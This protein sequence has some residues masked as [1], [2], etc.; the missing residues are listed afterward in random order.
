VILCTRELAV[1]IMGAVARV[2]RLAEIPVGRRHWFSL[3]SLLILLTL[4][5]QAVVPWFAMGFYVFIC[6]LLGSSLRRAL[7]EARTSKWPFRLFANPAGQ[8]F[9]LLVMFGYFIYPALPPLIG[10]AARQTVRL[11]CKSDPCNQ[12]IKDRAH[13]EL[14]F[15]NDKS[16]YL[17]INDQPNSLSGHNEYVEL[18]RESVGSVTYAQFHQPPYICISSGSLPLVRQ[19]RRRPFP[20]TPASQVS[21]HHHDISRMGLSL[22]VIGEASSQEWECALQ[23]VEL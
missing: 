12:I 22:R 7:R 2:T 18:S 9:V 23:P 8:M 16:L 3:V 4:L 1:V 21:R 13:V 19:R 14:G 15:A 20:W 6:A 17:V 11:T 5:I 10:G